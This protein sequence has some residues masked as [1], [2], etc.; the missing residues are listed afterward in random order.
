VSFISKY[1]PVYYNNM[2]SVQ[3]G[4][5]IVLLSLRHC[6]SLPANLLPLISPSFLLRINRKHT[7]HTPHPFMQQNLKMW[8]LP[9][10]PP[11]TILLPKPSQARNHTLISIRP[12]PLHRHHNTSQ[13][14]TH[15]PRTLSGRSHSTT[16]SSPLKPSRS[17]VAED[18]GS[19]S[20]CIS[21]A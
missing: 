13:P 4:P 10:L 3:A 14:L 7:P 9:L 16:Q 5:Y 11:L 17:A 12:A 21:A 20:C 19:A 2:D 8:H 18:G 15:P 1:L 6:V